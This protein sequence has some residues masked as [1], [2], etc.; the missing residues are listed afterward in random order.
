M[1]KSPAHIVVCVDGGHRVWHCVLPVLGQSQWLGGG[2]S[3]GQPLGGESGLVVHHAC[4][5][6]SALVWLV[7]DVGVG[8]PV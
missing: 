7:D 2:A 8:H 4:G 6:F 5:D 1:G 3:G